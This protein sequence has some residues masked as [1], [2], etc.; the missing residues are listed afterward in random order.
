MTLRRLSLIFFAIAGWVLA[1]IQAF[2]LFTLLNRPFD[3]SISLAGRH[4]DELLALHTR[5]D[6]T[7]EALTWLT[8][9]HG[10]APS[11]QVMISF[12]EWA[13]DNRETAETMLGQLQTDPAT[14]SRLAFAITDGCRG[15][16][17]RAAF[18]QSASS[19]I[20]AIVAETDRLQSL[21]P[22][23]GC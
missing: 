5:D 17:F 20:K 8:Q 9:Y 12:I 7:R 22:S 6:Q 4:T 19:P 3:D 2:L 1:G 23:S 14:T 11:H 13:I 10:E 18:E 21:T 15:N 16:A